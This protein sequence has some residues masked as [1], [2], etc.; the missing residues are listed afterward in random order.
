MSLVAVEAKQDNQNKTIKSSLRGKRFMAGW[1]T[2]LLEDILSG[3]QDLFHVIALVH[4][5][6][7]PTL[8]T[9]PA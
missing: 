4:S 7:T 3:K 8:L 2:D 1:N 9:Y 5:H 6:Q